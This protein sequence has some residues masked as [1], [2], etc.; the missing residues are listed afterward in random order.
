M[1]LLTCEICG[2]T[3]LIKKDG[4]FVCQTCGTKYSIEE[5]KKMMA[6]GSVDVSGS[7]VIVDKSGSVENYYLL[8]EKAFD[9][10]NFEEAENYCKKI[11]E[12]DPENYKAWMLKGK[13]AGWQST[14]KKLRVE[15][16]VVAFKKSME[17][18]GDEESSELKK[19]CYDEFNHIYEA[20]VK[21]AMNLFEEFPDLDSESKIENIISYLR[22]QGSSLQENDT[23]KAGFPG[24]EALMALELNFLMT[25]TWKKY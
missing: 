5:A 21:V 9:G 18:V 16:T 10:K 17:L 6:K 14:L 3:D 20:L 2:S 25:R 11:I 12:I 1:K 4:V 24:I 19:E 22:E 8:A 23:I 15:E 13:A 7:T